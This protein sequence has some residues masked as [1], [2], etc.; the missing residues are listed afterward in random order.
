MYSLDTYHLKSF[1]YDI[2]KKTFSGALLYTILISI[3]F[4]LWMLVF[5]SFLLILSLFIDLFI[6]LN[7]IVFKYNTTKILSK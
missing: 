3:N 1:L 2:Y 5:L 4:F 7:C 6:Y